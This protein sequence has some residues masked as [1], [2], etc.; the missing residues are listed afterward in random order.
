MP[1]TP[2][3]RALAQMRQSRANSAALNGYLAHLRTL[4]P[5]GVAAA[6]ENE[7]NLV[8]LFS[9]DLGIKVL[10]FLQKSVLESSLPPDANDSALRE[11]NGVRN[12]VLE[13][14]SIVAHG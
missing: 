13:L 1:Q 2:R 8:D 5:E 9:S 12:F 14:R 11:H 7:K 4:G 10:I 3:E 6:E